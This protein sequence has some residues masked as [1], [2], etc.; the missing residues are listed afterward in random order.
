MI[1]RNVLCQQQ[2][3]LVLKTCIRN[4]EGLFLGDPEYSQV[5]LEL[6]S[7]NTSLSGTTRV[8]QYQ[9]GKT[10]LNFTEARGSGISW[11]ICKSAPRSR[12]ITNSVK[13]LTAFVLS[14]SGKLV[15]LKRKVPVVV[16]VVV[17]IVVILLCFCD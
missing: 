2:V 5:F 3:H 11:V 16:F 10:S 15:K 13:A 14:I 17:I 6:H 9:K 7:F 4:P 1:F 8:S 12:H